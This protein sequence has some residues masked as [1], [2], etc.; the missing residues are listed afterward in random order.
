M[1]EI[2][3][4][5]FIFSKNI[6]V[7]SFLS[8]MPLTSGLTVWAVLKYTNC[9]LGGGFTHYTFFQIYPTKVPK[10]NMCFDEREEA[11]ILQCPFC[12]TVVPV[13]TTGHVDTELSLLIKNKLNATMQFKYS[14]KSFF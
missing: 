6:S 10:M 2:W 14:Y 1:V 3:K 13:H 8:Y 5:F 12:S 9:T 7:I 4:C 11:L